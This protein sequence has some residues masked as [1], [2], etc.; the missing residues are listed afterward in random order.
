MSYNVNYS[1]NSKSPLIVDDNSVNSQTS[2][3]LVGRKYSRYGEAI[4]EN[5]LHLLENFADG[6][7][8]NSPIQGQIWYDKTNNIM[9]YY[10]KNNK[11]QSFS[12]IFTTNEQPLNVDSRVGDIWIKPS[13][14]KIHFYNNNEWT[15]LG[16]TTVIINESGD[17]S[18]PTTTIV[19]NGIATKTR[20]D[21]Q[22]NSHQTLEFI[23]NSK[24]VS[25]ISSDD[26]SWIPASVGTN[27]EY[28]EGSSTVLLVSQFLSIKKGIN[29]NP[30]GTTKYNLHNYIVSE[31]GPVKINVGRGDVY[32]EENQYDNF[33]GAGLTIRTS[34]N[35][36]EGSIFSVRSSNNASRLWVGQNITS[37]PSNDFGV[38]LDGILGEEYKDLYNIKLTTTGTIYAKFAGGSW[39]ATEEEAKLGSLTNKLMTPATTKQL[40]DTYNFVPSGAIMAF[41]METIPTGWLK[42][43]GSSRLRSAYPLLFAAINTLY[44]QGN[45]SNSTTFNLPD[46]RGTFLRG[47][48]DGRGLD[49]NRSLGSYQ[50]DEIKSHNHTI[51]DPGHFH[52]VGTDDNDSGGTTTIDGSNTIS[53]Q[54][55]TSTSTTG[56]TI[57]STGGTETRPKNYAIIYCIKV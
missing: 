15:E 19:R 43:D 29:L 55:P 49:A 22:G 32:I 44:G 33:N 24:T 3:N 54:K 45:S 28:L 17:S 26:A 9:K 38:G 53:A 27:A 34:S 31:L 46:F 48:D 1:D 14:G 56:I 57:N 10:T 23:V 11:W 37:V 8:P 39:L 30:S 21:T 2:V 12:N 51:T 47:K 20:K 4:S 7:A 5:F 13:T 18:T 16:S 6:T 50:D 35:P 25:V 40:V 52:T 42:C 41:A 36:V